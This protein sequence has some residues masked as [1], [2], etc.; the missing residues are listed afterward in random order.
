MDSFRGSE[1]GKKYQ[2][3]RYHSRKKECP[4]KIIHHWTKK[5][6]KERGI[7][8][9]LTPESIKGLYPKDGLCPVLGTPL[10]FGFN[11]NENSPTLDRLIPSRGYVVGNVNMISMRANRMKNDCYDPAVF[12]RIAGWLRDQLDA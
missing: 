10:D 2:R 3:N 4:E 11:N 7:K 6:A 9:N 8:F 1:K 12:E 5:R